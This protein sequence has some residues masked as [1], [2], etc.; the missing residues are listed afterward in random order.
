MKR[1]EKRS[2]REFI[3]P[4]LE[5]SG[6]LDANTKYF[7]NPTGRFVIGG[8]LGDTGLTGRKDNFGHLWWHG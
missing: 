3:K 5:P 4:V 7:I 6:L 1:L 2:S 8:P